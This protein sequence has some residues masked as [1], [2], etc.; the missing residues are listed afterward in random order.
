MDEIGPCLMD[1]ILPEVIYFFEGIGNILVFYYPLLP[2]S[3]HK[4]V[5]F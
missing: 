1:E 5:P 2:P 3:W 4:G